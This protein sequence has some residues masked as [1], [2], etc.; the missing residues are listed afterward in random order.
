VIGTVGR[1]H[2][3]LDQQLVPLAT[4]EAFD[5]FDRPGYEKFVQ[6]FRITGGGD[7]A[8]YTLLAE[9]RTLALDPCAREKL[10]LYWYLLVGWS[11]NWLLRMLLEAV[12]RRAEGGTTS[13]AMTRAALHRDRDRPSAASDGRTDRAGGVR[14]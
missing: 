8:G 10:A 7:G 6:S 5:A 11:G 1:L 14:W 12:K 9:H 3:L 4:R 13:D 2:D